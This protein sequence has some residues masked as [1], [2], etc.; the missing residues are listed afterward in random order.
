MAVYISNNTD[1]EMRIRPSGDGHWVVL[2][3]FRC[4]YGRIEDWFPT[5]RMAKSHASL[6]YKHYRLGQNPPKRIT[7]HKWVLE[8][9]KLAK[10]DCRCNAELPQP[11]GE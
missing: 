11:G 9:P 7:W 2:F 3:G 5:L 4:S 6:E 8:S 1:P 10:G